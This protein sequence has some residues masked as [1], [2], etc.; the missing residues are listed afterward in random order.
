MGRGAGDGGG[1]GGGD[2]W[3]AYAVY[4]VHTG[5]TFLTSVW[6]SVAIIRA[7]LGLSR[8]VIA[9]KRCS[10]MQW[11]NYAIICLKLRTIPDNRGYGLMIGRGRLS[12][13]HLVVG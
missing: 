2:K 9:M 3:T 4:P 7:S 12:V 10:E 5:H 13:R 11:L 1:D 6:F 8:A